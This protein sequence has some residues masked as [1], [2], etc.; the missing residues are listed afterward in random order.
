MELE[1]SE[2]SRASRSRKRKATAQKVVESDSDDAFEKMEVDRPAATVEES[3]EDVSDQADQQTASETDS[4]SDVE[5]SSKTVESALSPAIKKSQAPQAR[6]SQVEEKSPPSRRTRA[7]TAER[8]PDPEKEIN[9][10]PRRELPF[11]QKSGT[12]QTSSSAAAEAGS[13]TESDDEL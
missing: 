12:K 6:L 11:A 1:T 10:P 13:E 8:E 9:L 2:P 4:E 7:T 5:V 3:E